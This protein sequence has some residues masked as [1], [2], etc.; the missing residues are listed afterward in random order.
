MDRVVSAYEFAIEEAAST[1]DVD[2][3][4]FMKELNNTPSVITLNVWPWSQLVPWFKRDIQRVSSDSRPRSLLSCRRQE[5]AR[6]TA[7]RARAC[8]LTMPRSV[9]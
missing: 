5:I 1:I 6:P 2:T 7:T 9:H 4:A 8:S 3:D